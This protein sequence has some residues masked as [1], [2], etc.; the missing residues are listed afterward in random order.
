MMDFGQFYIILGTK[1][2]DLGAQFL[3]MM[4]SLYHYH[5][6]VRICSYILYNNYT[7]L[8]VDYVFEAFW[9]ILGI[10]LPNLGPGFEN[11]LMF[12]FAPITKMRSIST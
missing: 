8:S 7:F 3:I 1:I 9:P 5:Q 12:S 6:P 11:L 10:A 2:L 4:V